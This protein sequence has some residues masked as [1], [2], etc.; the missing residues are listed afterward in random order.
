MNMR[1]IVPGLLAVW[2][3]QAEALLLTPAN[4]LVLPGDYGPSNCEPG[5][6]EKVFGTDGVSLLY[7]AE[8]PKTAL[9][10]VLE[11]GLFA[12]SYQTEFLHTSTD[13]SGAI[14]AYVGGPSIVC[15]ECF[16]AIKDGKSTPGYYFFNLS[17]WNGIETIVLADFWPANGAISHISIWGDHA[18]VPEP[19]TLS[20]LGAGLLL[21][22]LRNRRKLFAVSLK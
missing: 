5:C 11:E 2:A 14:L 21:V 8:T 7:Q 13:P 6:V 3:F 10:P 4:P 12:G 9:D 16:L 18:S 1:T 17:K 20:L 22:G 15:D 19:G